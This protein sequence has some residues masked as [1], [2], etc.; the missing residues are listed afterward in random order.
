MRLLFLLCLLGMTL[1]VPA[2]GLLLNGDFEEENICTE[3]QQ[4]CAPEAWLETVPTYPYFFDDPGH[5]YHG[6]RYIGFVSGN[7]RMRIKRCYVRSRLLCGMRPGARYRLQLLVRAD[8]PGL[9]DS[10]GVQFSSYDILCNRKRPGELDADL[11]FVDAAPVPTRGGWA[12]VSYDY[13]ARGDEGFVTIGNFRR[14]D[15]GS[16]LNGAAERY[17]VYIDSVSLQPL[18]PYERLCPGWRKQ[19][20]TIYSEDNRH[21][22]LDHYIYGCSKLPPHPLVLPHNVQVRVD[23]LVVPDVLFATARADLDKKALLLLDSLM[24]RLPPESL[25]SIVVE[26]HTDNVGKPEANLQLS[27]ARA[28]AVGHY[29]EYGQNVPVLTRGWGAQRP[30]ADNR[31]PAGRRSNRRVEIYLFLRGS[32]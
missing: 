12:R 26:G 11:Y 23:T 9:I 1:A 6:Q 24:R 10:A 30:V 15:W 14:V 5:A 22:Y 13:T 18:D 4:N 21:N 17:Q 20:D 2:Q 31:S 3:Y 25:D 27:E 19:R 16:S 29:L 7:E 8:Y 28:Q 32:R